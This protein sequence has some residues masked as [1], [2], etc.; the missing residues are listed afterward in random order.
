MKGHVAK[1]GKRYYVVIDVGVDPNTGKRKQKWFSG[2]Q[3][4]K[5]SPSR[6]SRKTLTVPYRCIFG[7]LPFWR[8]LSTIKQNVRSSPYLKPL[9]Q[10]LQIAETLAIIGREGGIRTHGTRERTTVFKTVAFNHSATSPYLDQI[11]F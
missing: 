3:T 2:Y 5:R 6:T 11:Q 9:D 7:Q 4:K 10:S 1:K 8:Y